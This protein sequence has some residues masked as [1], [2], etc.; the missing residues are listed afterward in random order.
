MENGVDVVK[1]NLNNSVFE[2]SEHDATL[3]GVVKEWYGFASISGFFGSNTSLT[4]LNDD[5][6]PFEEIAAIIKSEPEGLF[7]E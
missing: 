5:G 4:A 6:T 3:P 2:F 1:G 7:K